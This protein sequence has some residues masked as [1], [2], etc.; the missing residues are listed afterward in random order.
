MKNVMVLLMVF[1]FVLAYTTPMFADPG[2]VTQLKDHVVSIVKSPLQIP[3]HIKAEYDATN[4]KPLGVM[5][6]L[7]KGTFYFGY[8]LGKGVFDIV[9]MPL[10][11]IKK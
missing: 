11:L 4:C 6:G 1:V 5:G 9:T 2:P 3:H 7:L 8:D 10:H